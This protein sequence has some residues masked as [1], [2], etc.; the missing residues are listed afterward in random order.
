MTGEIAAVGQD[1]DQVWTL[2]FKTSSPVVVV[3][4]FGIQHKDRLLSLKVGQTTTVQ[5]DG[6]E[7]YHPEREVVIEHCEFP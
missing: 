6:T 3:C 1:K 7:T 5:G 4:A 2:E